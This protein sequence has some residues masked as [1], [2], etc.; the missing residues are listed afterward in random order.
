MRGGMM[1]ASLSHRRTPAAGFT[2][3]EI[4][5]AI[6]LIIIIGAVSVASMDNIAGGVGRLS[7][8]Q[9]LLASIRQARYLAMS[10]MD[11]VMLTYNGEGHSFD[12]LDDKNNILEQDFCG[13]DNPTANVTLTFAPIMPLTDLVT[14]PSSQSDDDT[15]YSKVTT[16]RLLFHATGASS[17]VKV[18]L[19]ID[20]KDTTFHVDPFS[21]GPPPKFPDN[22]PTLPSDTN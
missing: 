14:D 22:V 17:P 4:L 12:L 9:A 3:A 2:L 11:T 7:P 15:Q 21:E 10:R 5:I 8:S 1:T 18:T 20:G 19:T 6:A 13:V 16:P